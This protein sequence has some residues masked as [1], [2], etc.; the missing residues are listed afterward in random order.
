MDK[1]RVLRKSLL[2]ECE[3]LIENNLVQGE[4]NSDGDMEF[5]IINYVGGERADAWVVR[6][7]ADAGNVWIGK[8]SDGAVWGPYNGFL[9]GAIDILANWFCEVVYSIDCKCES[10]TLAI[11]KDLRGELLSYIGRGIK[12]DN[13]QLIEPLRP[14]FEEFYQK[15]REK[16]G[17]ESPHQVSAGLSR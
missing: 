13:N 14:L 8:G 4:L 11:K 9:E 16:P 3:L 1:L 12:D 10:K 6:L 2:G 15:I 7:K 5:E 17:A